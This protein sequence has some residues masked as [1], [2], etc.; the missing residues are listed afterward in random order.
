MRRKSTRAAAKA[1]PEKPKEEKSPKKTRRH[2]KRHKPT[3][4]E[5]ESED[6]VLAAG[7]DTTAATGGELWTVTQTEQSNNDI[8]KIKICLARPSPATPERTERASKRLRNKPVVN[9]EDSPPPEEKPTRRTRRSRGG[10]SPVKKEE[11][12]QPQQQQPPD[13]CDEKKG[14]G[15]SK[16]KHKSKIVEQAAHAVDPE[17][18]E[19]QS[20]LSEN[21]QVTAQSPQ[22]V[23]I[24]DAEI[25]DRDLNRC[26]DERSVDTNDDIVDASNN[27]LSNNNVANDHQNDGEPDEQSNDAEPGNGYNGEE[28][29]KPL[30][31]FFFFNFGKKKNLFYLNFYRN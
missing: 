16:G 7:I 25:V 15:K 26:E 28:C 21:V 23:D 2:S 29:N 13:A 10:S 9:M 6:E 4:S 18:T 20:E 12:E 3:S 19:M 27:D 11:L 14:K 5:S 17:R 30:G 1:S 8:G 22:N 31:K 24:S